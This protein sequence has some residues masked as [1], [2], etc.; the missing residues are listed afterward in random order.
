M[1]DDEPVVEITELN[2]DQNQ[3]SDGSQKA[4]LLLL[5]A[6]ITMR[7]TEKTLWVL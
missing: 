6:V 5:V 3:P 1:D 4:K 7:S 2:Y